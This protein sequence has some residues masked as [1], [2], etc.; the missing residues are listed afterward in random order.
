MEGGYDLR[1]SQ[2]FPETGGQV[3]P[4]RAG[5]DNPGDAEAGG[6]VA[7]E[8]L[9]MPSGN[10][11]DSFYF[12]HDAGARNDPKISA[13]R[14]VY[15]AEGV[16]WFWMLIEV[17]REQPNYRLT[18]N[19]YTSQ[20]LAREL[21]CLATQVEK[22]LNDCNQEFVDD[23]GPLI[24]TDGQYF[25]SDSLSRRML[26][27][28]GKRELA[29]MAVNKR[30]TNHKANLPQLSVG[31]TDVLPT[32]YDGNTR[33]EKKRKEYSISKDI[34]K[35]IEKLKEIPE[36]I[37][38]N[39][40]I[41]FLEMRKKLRKPAT[42]RAQNLLIKDL[43]NFRAAGD[44][45]NAVIEQSIKNSWQGFFELKRG[46][47]GKNPNHE[48]GLSIPGRYTRPEDLRATTTGAESAR[49]P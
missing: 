7:I 30:W 17:L 34:H 35:D 46:G 11:K 37:D 9:I 43:E 26:V 22:F 13:M 19:K 25:W 33:K 36:F 2:L 8:G 21:G 5:A 23:S 3:K 6:V 4:G 1:E 49:Q 44:D 47:N 28:D 29:R 12:P 10:N 45:P 32:Q 15:G 14:T 27:I 42:A 48:R 38:K 41:D 24:N 18:V 39:L 16:G 20:S 40:W 31:N